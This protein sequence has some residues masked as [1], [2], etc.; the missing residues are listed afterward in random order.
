MVAV[1]ARRYPAALELPPRIHFGRLVQPG[2]REN[3]RLGAGIRRDVKIRR[4]C[5]NLRDAQCGDAI[6]DGGVGKRG[7]AAA[8]RRSDHH[9]CAQRAKF[10]GEF[11]SASS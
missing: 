8:G 5:D 4:S 1:I 11:L 2:A 7:F 6:Q 3:D 9:I 10:L